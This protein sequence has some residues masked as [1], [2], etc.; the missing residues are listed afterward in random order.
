MKKLMVAVALAFAVV[1]G[2][3]AV[4]AFAATPA[5]ATC[6]VPGC[7]EVTMEFIFGIASYTIDYRPTPPAAQQFNE[8]SIPVNPP[9]STAEPMLRQTDIRFVNLLFLRSMY[10]VTSILAGK[11]I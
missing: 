2:A 7:Y 8:L 4:S 6:T 1:G 9:A 5:A 3:V 11:I 10:V